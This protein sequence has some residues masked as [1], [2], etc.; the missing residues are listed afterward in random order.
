MQ[1]QNGGRFQFFDASDVTNWDSSTA[2]LNDGAWIVRQD[3][4]IRWNSVSQGFADS[5]NDGEVDDFLP[6]PSVEF[7]TNNADVT[8]DGPNS[9]MTPINFI[10]T[11]TG[12]FR[13]LNR[14]DFTTLDALNYEGGTLTLDAGSDLIANGAV[15]M[16]VGSRFEVTID[17]SSSSVPGVDAIADTQLDEGV[18]QLLALAQVAVNGAVLDVSV[19]TGFDPAVGSFWD[20]V[21]SEVGVTGV[22]D[23]TPIQFSP[24]G[25]FLIAEYDDSSRVRL[26]VVVPAPG[27]ATLLGA[28]G[29]LGLRRRRG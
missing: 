23:Y 4:E 10:E 28:A 26:R 17:G 13:L 15:S 11:N 9:V 16:N 20:I 12:A 2:T 6:A 5:D 21:V 22:F 29:L 24:S 1:A 18:G 19:P 7:R 27:A 14:R 3:S 25:N 8:L